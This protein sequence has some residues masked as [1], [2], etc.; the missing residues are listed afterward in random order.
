MRINDLRTVE[1]LTNA[2]IVS[3]VIADSLRVLKEV[4]SDRGVV[5][6]GNPDV[7]E[8][9]A[10]DFGVADTRSI[11]ELA[12]LKPL[13]E[14]KYFLLA[15]SKASRE[16]QN[17]LLKVIEEAPGDSVFFFVVESAGHLLPTILSRSIHVHGASIVQNAD[18]E[19][20]ET[21]LK[22][23]YE[24][25]LSTVEKM[26]SHISKTQDRGPAREFVAA[27]LVVGRA[28]GL[29]ASSL[30]DVLDADLYL[31]T[32]GG[33]PKAVLSHLAVSLPRKKRSAT[34]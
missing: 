17:A 10:S 32:Q 12:V 28:A 1:K 22:A 11:A 29:S 6:T 23:S 31:R 33:S 19:E 4:L 18:T 16:A 3:G 25:R 8:I 21:F 34:I 14:A 5:L 20:V 7:F 2:Y 30:R 13:G 15:I 9:S 27:L 26:T 24:S